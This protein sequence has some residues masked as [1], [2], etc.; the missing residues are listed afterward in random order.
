VPYTSS[1]LFAQLQQHK[2]G[3]IY[4][5]S[6][7]KGELVYGAHHSA[8]PAHNLRL[9]EKFFKPFVS[10]PFDDQCSLIYGRIRSDLTRMGT[11]IGPNDL[12][13]ASIAIRNQLT[14][15]TAN[16]REFGRVMGL[17]LANWEVAQ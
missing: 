1:T 13:I 4:L 15:V 10:L 14:L 9:L 3:D 17:S 7:V 8:H 6:L 11:R 16:T 12:W 2:P 5:C